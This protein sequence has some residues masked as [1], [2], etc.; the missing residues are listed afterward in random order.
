MMKKILLIMAVTL[1]SGSSLF[2]QESLPQI[3]KTQYN[4]KYRN[5]DSFKRTKQ[6]ERSA[7]KLQAPV[8]VNDYLLVYNEDLGYFSQHPT[9]VIEQINAQ[10]KF[11]RNNWRIPTP[12]ELSIMESNAS[13]LGLGSDIYMCTK[14]ANGYLR[15]VST[16]VDYSAVKRIGNTYWA[17][18]NLGALNERESGLPVSYQDA[19]KR[20]PNGYRLPT[21]EEV[22]ALIYSGEARFGGLTEGKTIFLPYTHTSRRDNFLGECQEETCLGEYWIQGG[23]IIYFY[24][25]RVC[26]SF[27]NYDYSKTQPEIRTGSSSAHVRYVLDK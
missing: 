15:P 10:N 12:E 5:K 8:T 19:I 20:A 3:D 25:H 21:K 6:P 7:Q 27:G 18:M 1:L 2:S 9:A 4:A 14:H 16:D 23:E 22:M 24:Y 13:I 17:K 26:I 11:G